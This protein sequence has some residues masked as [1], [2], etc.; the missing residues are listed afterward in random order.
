LLHDLALHEYL[1]LLEIAV[2]DRSGRVVRASA[3][4]MTKLVVNCLIAE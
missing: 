1:A 4:P 2:R 3:R